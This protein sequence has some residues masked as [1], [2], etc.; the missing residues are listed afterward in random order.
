MSD[1]FDKD[2]IL[3]PGHESTVSEII[4]ENNIKEEKTKNYIK[5]IDYITD[6]GKGK[7]FKSKD[8]NEYATSEAA[9]KAD[10][11]FKRNLKR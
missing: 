2:G 4:N 3:K 9:T 8:G 5:I 6:F 1:K 7:Y 10:D 11:Y